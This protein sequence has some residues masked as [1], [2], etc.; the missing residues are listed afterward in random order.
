MAKRFDAPL[1]TL[2]EESPPAWPTRL[3]YRAPAAKVID[4]DVSTVSGAADK[5]L[6]VRAKPDW[7]MHIEF[8][9]GPDAS[10]PSRTNWYNAVW[11]TTIELLL[12]SG[13]R[14]QT[15]TTIKTTIRNRRIEVPAPSEIPDG[16]EVILTIQA[17]AA[18]ENEPMPPEEISRVLA[19]MRKLEPLDIPEDVAADLDAWER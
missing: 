14:R 19:A 9:A 1:K 18:L 11:R 13:E 17:S 16:V 4:A 15:I 7:I 6:R 5:A 12:R 10:V 3:G 8:Q 2:F